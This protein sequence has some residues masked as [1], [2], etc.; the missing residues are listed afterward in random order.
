MDAPGRRDQARSEEEE[1]EWEE[2]DEEEASRAPSWF[3]VQAARL[4]VLELSVLS[5]WH[6]AL[7]AAVPG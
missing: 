4:R 2:E 7:A 5:R 3:G 1:E 6:E